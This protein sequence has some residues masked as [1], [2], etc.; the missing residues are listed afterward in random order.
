MMK[1][2]KIPKSISRHWDIDPAR[3]FQAKYKFGG[4][5]MFKFCYDPES[6][7]LLFNIPGFHHDLMILN[8]G[9]KEFDDYIRGICFW[10][11]KIIY[12]R[13]HENKHWLK[14]TKLM[15]RQNGIGRHIRIIWGE[16]AAFELREDLLGL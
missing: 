3:I 8:N 14:I 12:I 10:D 16:K 6:E 2:L 4:Q 5:K 7:E 1:D 9:K 11:K 13:G 15:L